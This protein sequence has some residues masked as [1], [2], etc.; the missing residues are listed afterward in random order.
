[1]KTSFEWYG[2]EIKQRMEKAARVGVNATMAEAAAY[3]KANHE[4]QNQTGTAE[5]SIRIAQNAK[6]DGDATYGLWGSVQV[7]YFQF[8]EFGTALRKAMPTLRPAARIAYP[9]LATLIKAAYAGGGRR[10]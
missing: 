3:A 8:L 5:R 7:G 2:D 9:R 10:A 6:T 1:M 4:W